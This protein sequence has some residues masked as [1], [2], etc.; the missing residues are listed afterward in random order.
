MSN[1]SHR[2]KNVEIQ[3]CLVSSSKN[4]LFKNVG[5]FNNIFE[6]DTDRK[7]CNWNHRISVMCIFNR[8]FYMNKILLLISHGIKSKNQVDHR[9]NSRIYIYNNKNL[10]K[11]NIKL[12]CKYHR[13]WIIYLLC[14]HVR[15]IFNADCI[16]FNQ[17]CLCLLK[18]NNNL[19]NHFIKIEY[20]NNRYVSN[21]QKKLSVLPVCWINQ[22][23]SFIIK[24][25][26]WP[27]DF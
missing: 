25:S 23:Q 27:K 12:C 4:N 15:W 6:L 26:M 9:I 21:Y 7:F 13:L 14:V 20:F 3:P 10:I 24:Y 1:I 17:Y 16:H 18:Y 8:N 22:K 5:F 11:N 2:L 19:P